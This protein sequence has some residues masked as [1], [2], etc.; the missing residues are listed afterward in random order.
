METKQEQPTVARYIEHR[1]TRAGERKAYIVGTRLAV[2]NIYV[3]HELQ[4][5]SPDQI[6]AAYPQASLAQ[7][8][9]ALAYFFDHAEEVRA[10]LR[11]SEEF[12]IQ[13]EAD[14]GATKFTVLR[15]A[16]LGTKNG[17]NGDSPAP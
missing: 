1:T 9:A 12:A 4:G 11:R 6:V 14:Q 2:E 10:Q 13:I 5:M 8:H 17:G 7:V 3:C 16:M 15:D